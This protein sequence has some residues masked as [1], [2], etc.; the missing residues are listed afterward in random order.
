MESSGSLQVTGK[1]DI[2][3]SKPDRKYHSALKMNLNGIMVSEKHKSMP[4]VV[5]QAWVLVPGLRRPRQEDHKFE[6]SLDYIMRPF[7]R[8]GEKGGERER[9]KKRERERERERERGT[10]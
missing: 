4:G 5:V 3:E 10:G 2:R 8:E 7:V 6:A 9:K 1:T